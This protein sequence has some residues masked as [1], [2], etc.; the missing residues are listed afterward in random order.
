MRLELL[1]AVFC[2][3]LVN[4]IIRSGIFQIT[5]DTGLCWANL[6][7]CRFQTSR[8]AVIAERAFFCGMRYRVH[9][10]AAVRAGLNTKTTSDAILRIDKNRAVWRIESRANRANL[11]ARR[12]MAQITQL[13]DEEGM[14]D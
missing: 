13:R 4:W 14:L 5:K 7:A 3:K 12:M 9:E 6:H 11:D 10:A 8:D 1:H 2:V